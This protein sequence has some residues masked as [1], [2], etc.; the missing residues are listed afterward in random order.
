MVGAG[1]FLAALL[2]AAPPAHAS[3]VGHY[4]LR[5]V[6]DAAS[7]LVLHANGRFEFALAY[8]AL[9]EEAAGRWRRVGNQILLTTT[10]KPVP[11]AFSPAKAERTTQAPLA[12]H[13]TW[14]N[15]RGIPGIDFRVEFDS[16]APFADYI[17]NDEGW[18]LDPAETR[19]PVA[20]TLAL[21]MYDLVSP[22]F[23]IDAAKANDLTFILTPHDLGHYDF[24]DT[25]LDIAPGKL[26]MHRGQGTLDYVRE[27]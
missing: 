26:V 2:L 21:T 25:P 10:P 24:E 1:S 8:G 12:L 11:A 18:Q 7:E 9:D 19:K 15:G 17:N 4:R 13:V 20:V 5:N 16:G 27:R 3:P 23:P 22:R 6:H 14:P